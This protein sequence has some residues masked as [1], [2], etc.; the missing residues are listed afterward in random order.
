MPGAAFTA[1]RPLPIVLTLDGYDLDIERSLARR[2]RRPRPTASARRGAP[3]ESDLTA[4][5]GRAEPTTQVTGGEGARWGKHREQSDRVGYEPR[6][7]EQGAA[8][9]DERPLDHLVS[10]PAARLE[11]RPKG[12]PGPAPLAP[13]E[14]R[15]ED[16]VEQQQG[17]GEREPDPP[18]DLED[19]GEFDDRDDNE[20]K[21]QQWQHV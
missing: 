9:E 6:C 2:R 19:D 1:L 21:Q 14:H 15:P 8:D 18:A 3:F 17:K 13:Y 12:T 4:Q 16:A 7:N 10:G 20:R 5:R 11:R